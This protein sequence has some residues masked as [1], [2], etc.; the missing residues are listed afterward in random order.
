MKGIKSMRAMR[1]ISNQSKVLECVELGIKLS[2]V[3]NKLKRGKKYL[4][5][6]FSTKHGL[7]AQKKK[8]FDPKQIVAY[9]KKGKKAILGTK[10]Y[11]YHRKHVWQLAA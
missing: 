4:K 10:A 8:A 5:V 6:Q 7:I 2:Q 9:L 1:R 3:K 11:V